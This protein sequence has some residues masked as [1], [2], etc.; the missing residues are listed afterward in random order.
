MTSLQK[1]IFFLTTTLK[2]HIFERE[3]RDCEIMRLKSYIYN[4]KSWSYDSF[5]PEFMC[6]KVVNLWL[7]VE[8]SWL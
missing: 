8:K 1:K 3:K 7:N 4:F 5:S 2:S 6:F